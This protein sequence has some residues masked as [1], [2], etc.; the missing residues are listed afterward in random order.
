MRN[1]FLIAALAI[2]AL[3]HGQTGTIIHGAGDPRNQSP[4][5]SCTFSKFY[6][7]DTT[8]TTYSASGSPCVWAPAGGASSVAAG[9]GASWGAC[10]GDSVAVGT[11]ASVQY[12]SYCSLLS[13]D[14]PA[15]SFTNLGEGGTLMANVANKI[16]A[17]TPRVNNV[18]LP[19]PA[20]FVEGGINDAFLNGS[21]AG[22]TNNYSL[23]LNAAIAAEE[24]P[25]SLQVMAS[26]ATPTG[27]WAA[28]SGSVPLH[29]SW[30][31]TAMKSTT[32]GSTLTFTGNTGTGTKVGLTW[33]AFVV[34]DTGT[35][36][37]TVNGSSVNNTCTGT[38][39]FNAFGC[40]GIAVNPTT[41]ITATIMRQD[42][43]VTPGA[44]TVVVTV[45]SATNAS[46]PVTILDTDSYPTS[47]ANQPY[48]LMSGVIYENGDAASAATAAMNSTGSSVIAAMLANNLNV[49]FVDVRGG[50]P[51]VN[52]ST[53]MA[54]Q[55]NNQSAC[56]SSAGS[57]PLHPNDCG[58]Y[59][60]AQTFEN[61]ASAAGLKLFSP[62]S[63]GRS[64]VIPYG[65]T[66]EGSVALVNPSPSS[67][68][69]FPTV[70]SG[71]NANAAYLTNFWNTNVLSAVP[72]S[73]VF[74]PGIAFWNTTGHVSGFS[75][76]RHPTRALFPTTA[77]TDAAFNVMICPANPATPAA[78]TEAL[79]IDSVGV[80]N[81]IGTVIPSASTIAPVNAIFHVSGTTT[82]NVM[83]APA[84]CTTA[85]GQG[86]QLTVIPDGIF[87]TATGGG[88]GGFALA[89]TAVVNKAINFVYDQATTL[90]YPSY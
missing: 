89:T 45:S 56:L 71:A 82:I 37:V 67:T 42:F 4:I 14:F 15:S 38:T 88:A 12:K 80:H 28:D 76:S 25:V 86:C 44:Y 54:T 32:N 16:L 46:N 9:S 13:N 68:A 75:F 64:T 39:T 30:A 21:V 53:D 1:I 5:P 55:A 83:T 85:T 79:Y 69:N 47:K 6:I 33:M 90:W 34:A 29:S 66:V 49:T 26:T 22:A 87:A 31:G 24:I 72:S 48:F 84:T 36:T 52:S 51:G 3:A 65:L 57:A 77:W 2:S 11:G 23:E 8:G 17:N 81:N 61:A 70:S 27:S 7:D 41:A 58:H 50:T 10:F 73:S 43:T 18:N 19:L 78:C 62:Q 74:S 63:G 40:N 35:F 60:Y 59:H 20:M